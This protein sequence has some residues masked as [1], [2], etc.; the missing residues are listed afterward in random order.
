MKAPEIAR[1]SARW[2]ALVTTIAACTIVP[3]A[4]P[5]QS[6]PASVAGTTP[7]TTPVTTPTPPPVTVQP[8]AATPTPTVAP[9]A[10]TT[11]APTSTEA[12]PSRSSRPGGEADPP[13]EGLLLAGGPVVAG[14]P[15]TY[16]YGGTCVDM[17]RWPPK[18]DLPEVT[19]SAEVFRFS[20]EGDM[21]FMTWSAA[22]ARTSSD[23]WTHLDSGGTPYDPDAGGS[24]PPQFLS[25]SFP[26]PPTGDWVVIM[27]VDLE[28]GDLSYAW[29]VTVP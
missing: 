11:P 8:S 5:T 27:A 2:L 22:Y 19:G 4:R 3:A 1:S 29:H 20:L 12:P 24:A 15:G 23:Q 21:P 18:A 9:T 26:S 28:D 17:A 6:V 13:P 16:C 25:A 7:I 14:R 10:P